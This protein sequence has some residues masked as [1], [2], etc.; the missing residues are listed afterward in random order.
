M[1]PQVGTAPAGICQ[2]L[3]AT[4]QQAH[5][6][7]HAQWILTLTPRKPRCWSTFVQ[8]SSSVSAV[9][10]ISDAEEIPSN[11]SAPVLIS[12]DVCRMSQLSCSFPM[13][14]RSQCLCSFVSICVEFIGSRAQAQCKKGWR[15][16]GVPESNSPSSNPKPCLR[17]SGF[18]II[19]II[20]TTATL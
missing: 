17:A 6:T 14:M 18:L 4:C 20:T 3:Q 10:L 5:T 2:E 16:S 12:A 8:K 13:P 9:V 19:S 7:A 11:V 1:C 15:T